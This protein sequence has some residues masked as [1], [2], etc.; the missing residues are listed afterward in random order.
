MILPFMAIY[1]TGNLIT[2]IFSKNATEEMVEKSLQTKLDQIKDEVKAK[3]NIDITT[4]V[5]SAHSIYKTIVETAEELG[6]DSIVMGTHGASGLKKI[7]GSNAQRVI[8]QAD[9]PVI[10]MKNILVMDIRIL[11]SQST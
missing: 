3:H 9:V 8:S 2:S 4:V 11:Y 7:M 6:C 5:R 1:D 10:V